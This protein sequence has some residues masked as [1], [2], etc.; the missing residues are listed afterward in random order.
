M[1]YIQL[2]SQ[3]YTIAG[4]PKLALIKIQ[5]TTVTFNYGSILIAFPV[6]YVVV[7]L[8]FSIIK[9]ASQFDALRLLLGISHCKQSA[10]KASI[11][12]LHV[13]RLHVSKFA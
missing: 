12:P 13:H 7:L 10:S 1:I 11:H 8:P 6:S 3:G 9:P 2:A 4:N 5:D